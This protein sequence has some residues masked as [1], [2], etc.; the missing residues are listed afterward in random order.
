MALFD[1]TFSYPKIITFSSENSI[2][3]SNSTFNSTPV[4]LGV[5]DYD[6]VVMTHANIPKSFYNFPAGYNTFQLSELGHNTTITIIPGSYNIINIQTVLSALLTAGSTTLGNNWTY[7]V[8][9]A[10]PTVGDTY[11]LT[12]AVSGNTGQ[13]SI[14]MYA[15]ELSPFR[16]LGFD[17]N[18]TYVFVANSLKSVN[19]VNLALVLT[20]FIVSDVCINSYKGILQEF[21]NIG[22]YPPLSVIYFDQ[23]NYDINTKPFNQSLNSSWSF[24]LVDDLFLPIDTLGVPWSFTLCFFK[25]NSTHELQRNR[26]E[27]DIEQ[28]N[29]DIEQ[30]KNAILDNVRELNNQLEPFNDTVLQ[31]FLDPQIIYPKE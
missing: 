4:N 2:S 6:S 8:T 15:A 27:Y 5:N 10:S 23:I 11:K 29:F 19:A 1:S 31:R 3:G 13:P 20:A 25:R 30:Q 16:Q 18:Q 17:D 22:S 14:T 24:S 9:Y 12:F 26:L 7:S 28:K 21:L